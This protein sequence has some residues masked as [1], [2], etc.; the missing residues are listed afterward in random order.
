M[1]EAAAFNS[2]LAG[3]VADQLTACSGWR[4]H[5]LVAHL[6]AGSAAI[7]QNVTAFNEGGSDSVPPT[8]GLE[9][10]ELPYREMAFDTLCGRLGESHEEMMSAIGV[11]LSADPAA[12]TPWAGRHMPIGAF[13]THA[14][15]EYALHRWDLVG[16][17]EI[18]TELLAQPELTDHAVQ[19]LGEVLTGRGIA[20]GAEGAVR[21]SC[22][23][24][25]DI[26]VGVGGVVYAEPNEHEDAVAGDA[27]ARLL[28]LWGRSPNRPG[29][30]RAPGGLAQL[31]ALKNLLAGY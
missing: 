30:L 1:A 31:V 15:S 5:E 22:E 27:A 28:L 17:D 18:G 21:L 24:R 13:V 7:V 16:D 10:R 20:G 29:R 23:G 3:V 14:R 8:I 26:S 9:E 25:P 2:T 4:A 12:I 19:A 6:A 11:A